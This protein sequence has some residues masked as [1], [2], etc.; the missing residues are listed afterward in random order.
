MIISQAIKHE[1][2][3]RKKKRERTN[4]IWLKYSNAEQKDVINMYITEEF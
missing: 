1:N 4:T 2:K 3:K